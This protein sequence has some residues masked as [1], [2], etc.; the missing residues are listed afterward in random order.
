MPTRWQHSTSCEGFEPPCQSRRGISA[1]T[2]PGVRGAQLEPAREEKGKGVSVLPEERRA[3]G[4]PPQAGVLETCWEVMR[5]WAAFLEGSQRASHKTLVGR[6]SNTTVMAAKAP[7]HPA[8]GSHNEL[9]LLS[10]L[11]SVGSLSAFQVPCKGF[12]QGRE[13]DSHLRPTPL[14]LTTQ[15]LFAGGRDEGPRLGPF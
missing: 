2:R 3:W 9:L 10:T 5:W 14:H 11:I 12:H 6:E 1:G 13:E 15:P 7:L 4:R 8:W